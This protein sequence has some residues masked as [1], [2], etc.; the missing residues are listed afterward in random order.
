MSGQDTFKLL[1]PFDRDDPEFVLSFECG[2]LWSVLSQTDTDYEAEVHVANAEMMRLA[3]ATERSVR[4]EELGD[5][6][7]CVE[8]SERAE[9]DAR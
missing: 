1:L 5:G 7:L 8:F 9:G 4:S 3:E 6:W 2:R